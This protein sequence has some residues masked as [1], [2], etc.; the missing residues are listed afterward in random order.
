MATDI[1]HTALGHGQE[2][3]PDRHA[4][5]KLRWVFARFHEMR[6]LAYAVV[7]ISLIGLWVHPLY[8]PAGDDVKA[9][10]AAATTQPTT[11]ASTRPAS[12][13][14]KVVKGVGGYWRL[15]QDAGGV[16]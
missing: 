12:A 2:V 1:K 5:P 9:T 11:A 10:T 7:V 16:W 4:A 3:C 6:N 13:A 8:T 14:Y 15:A